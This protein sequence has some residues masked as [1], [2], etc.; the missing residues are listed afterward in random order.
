MGVVH[1]F[2]IVQMVQNRATQHLSKR[3]SLKC[4]RDITI[5]KNFIKANTYTPGE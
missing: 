1:V 5:P 3:L 2:Y 4:L